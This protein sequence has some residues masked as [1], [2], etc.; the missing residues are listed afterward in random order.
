MCVRNNEPRVISKV[1]LIIL[2]IEAHDLV[3]S[4]ESHEKA[5]LVLDRLDGL[6]CQAV[7]MVAIESSMA[8][9]DGSVTERHDATLEAAYRELRSWP[10]R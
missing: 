8:M 2:F 6:L 9:A 3:G 1:G 7:P 5:S 4:G 10:T